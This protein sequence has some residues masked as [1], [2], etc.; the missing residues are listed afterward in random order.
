[1]KNKVTKRYWIGIPP[2]IILG[3]VLILV[4]IFVFIT[5]ENIHRQKENTTTLLVEKGAALIRSFEAG[6]RTGMMGMMGM[7]GGS[8]RLQKL[9]TETAQEPDIVYLIVTDF[10]GTIL[11]HNDPTK[12]GGTHGKDLDLERI[13][14]SKDVEWRQVS[15]PDGT[16][17][18]EVFRRFSPT[19]SHFRRHHGRMM[20]DTAHQSRMDA[21]NATEEAAKL[22][23]VGLD[24]GPVEI[25]RKEDARHTVVM[26]LILLLIGFAGIVSL[27]LAQAY[28]STRASL[29]RVKAFS[30]NLVETMPIG[31]LATGRD[32]RVA[33]FN[34]TA[35][36]VLQLSSRKVLWKIPQD[37]LPKPML[38]LIDRL[39]TESRVIVKEIDCPVPGSKTIPLEVIASFLED[40]KGAFLGY[41]ILFRDLSEIRHLKREV[42]RSQRLASIGKLASGI[43]HEIRNPLSSIKGFATYF[44]ERYREVP[45]DQKTADIMIKEVERLNR[46]IGQLLEFARPM[47]IK[48]KP[49]SIR[50]LVQD[51]LKMIE[52]AAQKK[53]IQVHVSS[54]PPIE[55]SMD[56][57]R[58]KQVFLNVY[59]NAIEAME[60]GG[61]LSVELRRDDVAK[62]IEVTISDTGTGIKEE[63]LPHVFDPYFTTK[64]S[65]T[66]LGLAIVHK[67]IESHRGKVTVK[68]RNGTG[69]TVT[70]ILPEATVQ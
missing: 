16:D 13:S 46:V 20:S 59:I 28:R 63:D 23:F 69:T 55:I 4:P 6:A 22:I 17:T 54:I 3:A 7:R 26:A 51:S 40:E 14:V 38:D 1:M 9:L 32:G 53:A 41:V 24:R 2:W 45:E 37:V 5:L 64:S 62:K 8:F 70:I 31:L 33:S 42:E 56:P 57:D 50:D 44:K 58:M 12:I 10:E 27:F 36:S 60:N 47:S 43:A 30:D 39:K 34:Q 66:G 35:E 49:T 29:S 11:S 19:A 15:N 25:A 48:K 61:S 18:F 65:G 52:G 21:Y 68:R 67:I